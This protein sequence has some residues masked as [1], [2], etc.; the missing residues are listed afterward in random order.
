MTNTKF[1]AWFNAQQFYHWTS[2]VKTRW[3]YF[4][5]LKAMYS[6]QIMSIFWKQRNRSA[7]LGT[8]SE[9]SFPFHLAWCLPSKAEAEFLRPLHEQAIKDSWDEILQ[10]LPKRHINWRQRSVRLGT[11]VCTW[12]IAAPAAGECRFP[13]KTALPSSPQEKPVRRERA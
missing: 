10:Q 13:V 2:Y 6:V 9:Y 11:A 8:R 7:S 3:G 5:T 4:P 1:N 12:S